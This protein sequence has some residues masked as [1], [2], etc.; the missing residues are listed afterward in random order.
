[1][2]RSHLFKNAFILLVLVGVLNSVAVKLHLYWT[3]H[4]FDSLVHFTAG[5]SVGFAALWFFSRSVTAKNI[6]LVSFAMTLFVGIIWEIFELYFNITYLSD[7]IHYV[8]DTSFDLVMDCLGALVAGF[9]SRKY[10]LL[11]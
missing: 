2:L 9:Y 11:K 6:L 7:G 4:Y 1:M 5:V 3:L 10:L 8:T